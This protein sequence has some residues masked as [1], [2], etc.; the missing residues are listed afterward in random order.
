MRKERNEEEEEKRINDEEITTDRDNMDFTAFQPSLPIRHSLLIHN[1]INTINLNRRKHKNQYAKYSI[2]IIPKSTQTTPS[3]TK[4]VDD[5][6]YPP[7]LPHA[8]RP[9]KPYPT[10]RDIPGKMATLSRDSKTIAHF[11]SKFPS[12][13]PSTLPALIDNHHTPSSTLTHTELQE[14]VKYVSNGLN[15]LGVKQY[16]II[17]LFSESSYRWCIIDLAIMSLGAVSAVR[18][19]QAPCT[20]LKYI[21]SHSNSKYLIIE[22]RQTLLHLLS[23]KPDLDHIEFIV[24]LFGSS[25]ECISDLETTNIK[26]YSF[27]EVLETGKLSKLNFQF[28]GNRND[29]A[30][31][32]YT[33]GTTGNPKGVV[34]T[35]DNILRQL[36]HISLGNT[37]DPKVGEI[38]VS[39]LPCWHVFERTA[40]YWC[41]SKGMT[42][43]Y[44]NKRHF[45]SDLVKHKPH[46]LISVPR[47][48]DN[49][50]CTVMSKM[51]KASSLQNAIFDFF[52][53]I[54][55]LFITSR[56]I[57]Q[58]LVIKSSDISIQIK[59]FSL[60]KMC[61]LFPL[62]A[63]A[64]LLIW[65][66]IRNGL[67]GRL[68]ICLSGGG[69][70]ATYLEDFFESSGI[71]IYVGYGLTETSPVIANRF[72]GRNIRGTTG[73]PLTATHVKLINSATGEIIKKEGEQGV[74]FV[75]GPCV[76]NGYLNDENA[77][78]KVFDNDGYFDTGDLASY[79]STGELVM[80]G[81]KKDLI[82]LS[83]GE[84]IEP[85][86][87][88]DCLLSSRFIDQVMLVG[89]DQ[90]ALGALIV[91]MFDQLKEAGILSEDDKDN[92]DNNMKCIEF[93]K[94]EIRHLNEDRI[95][96]SSSNDRIVHLKFVTTPFSV[97]NGMMTQ[98]LKLKKDVISI[99]YKHVIDEMYHHAS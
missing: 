94:N 5:K 3:S 28:I 32:L 89:Q 29:M 33:S 36:E 76:F 79:T 75:S 47:V 12:C 96:Y 18:G 95:A 93:M 16:D 91:P 59:I 26:I 81:R 90:R 54:T 64:H 43:V 37:S 67:G 78:K 44:S 22:N 72:D 13:F 35:H 52:A 34:L 19:T 10:P 14:K 92:L 15:V 71:T 51:R 11:F 84:N 97:D 7:P 86:G 60:M 88:E 55:M 6:I 40:A 70:I 1:H 8:I 83:N 39:I 77:T 58:G 46:M 41:L 42:L 50:H 68:R 69:S 27:E 66:K 45:K 98:T 49:L 17:S 85:S 25:S 24:L 2:K 87:I 23:S 38:I 31:L 21:I 56:R 65:K 20:E 61:L 73:L 74:L 63:L 4:I 48:F 82:V 62:W 80:D 53:N 57:V 9:P 30:T 99:K